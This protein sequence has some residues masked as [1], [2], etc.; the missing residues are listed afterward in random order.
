MENNSPQRQN[1]Q[2]SVIF[3]NPKNRDFYRKRL[4]LRDEVFRLYRNPLDTGYIRNFF[5]AKTRNKWDS[6]KE[7]SK[8]KE[9]TKTQVKGKKFPTI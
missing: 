1:Q 6:T 5:G 4:R 8:K 2:F 7:V 3:G 9:F